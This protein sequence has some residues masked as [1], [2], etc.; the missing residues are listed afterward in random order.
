MQTRRLKDLELEKKWAETGSDEGDEAEEDEDEM[1]LVVQPDDEEETDNEDDE[2]IKAKEKPQKHLPDNAESKKN[3]AKKTQKK[4]RKAPEALP[5]ELPAK[6][7]NL[8]PIATSYGLKG[9]FLINSTILCMLT[10][11]ED[12]EDELS[13][14]LYSTLATL[15]DNDR[16]K[17]DKYDET[18]KLITLKDFI[19]CI[20]TP[21]TASLLIAHDRDIGLNDAIDVQDASNKCGDMCQSDDDDPS[22]AIDDIHRRNIRAMRAQKTSSQPPRYRKSTLVVLRNSWM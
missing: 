10:G 16:T 6:K 19:S 15:I 22:G 11:D 5:E 14:T 18:S 2:P 9:E 21:F 13:F 1:D 12:Y 20:I 3:D 8:T 4:K 7:S 17:F